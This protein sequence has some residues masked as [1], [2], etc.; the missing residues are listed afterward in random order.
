MEFK[1][2]PARSNGYVLVVDD[3]PAM[4][5]LI[6]GWLHKAGYKTQIVDNYEA[7]KQ[8]LE[9][10]PPVVIVVDDCPNNDVSLPWQLPQ[11]TP[12]Q[13][14]I[15]PNTAVIVLSEN[16]ARWYDIDGPSGWTGDGPSGFTLVFTKPFNPWQLIH[17]CDL[18]VS[19]RP[20]FVERP[21]QNPSPDNEAYL[22]MVLFPNA[23][24]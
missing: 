11:Y 7:A 22:E 2:N 3:V 23:F 1:P 6:A 24:S 19:S 13:G 8:I 12:E 5:E 21:I 14:W 16:L 17:Y 18:C 4:A 10:D 9:S 20:P 15:Y